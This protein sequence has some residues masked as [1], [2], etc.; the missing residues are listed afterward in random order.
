MLSIISDHLIFINSALSVRN[1]FNWKAKPSNWAPK[2]VLGAGVGARSQINIVL[3]F[4]SKERS[5][6]NWSALQPGEVVTTS[7]SSNL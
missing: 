7:S 6:D 3:R 2:P 4:T 1:H 5:M